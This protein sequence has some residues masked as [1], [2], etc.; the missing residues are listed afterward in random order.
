M[1]PSSL[2]HPSTRPCRL[3]S[4]LQGYLA[5]TAIKLW[6]AKKSDKKPEYFRGREE[7]L[8]RWLDLYTAGIDF[9]LVD[10]ELSRRIAHQL[11]PLPAAGGP[12]AGAVLVIA[13]PGPE[14]AARAAPA[15]T[16]AAA[17]GDNDADSQ[18]GRGRSR[19]RSRPASAGRAGSVDSSS[20]AAVAPAG[21][22]A[23]A[24]AD[25][26]PVLG[27]IQVLSL[28]LPHLQ[29]LA[30]D[31][32][33]VETALLPSDGSSTAT[34]VDMSAAGLRAHAAAAQQRRLDEARQVLL[35]TVPQLQ[36]ARFCTGEQQQQ[37]QL[38]DWMVACA[39]TDT[40]PAGFEL[41]AAR[42]A[43]AADPDLQEAL[44][45]V[46]RDRYLAFR[47]LPGLKLLGIVKM[48]QQPKAGS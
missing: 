2:T 48:V 24:A 29:L 14:P 20:S 43:V 3:T 27:S 41:Q 19:S 42:A 30:E 9:V 10:Q 25:A 1:P 7:L 44:A 26:S 8:A 11:P 40:L 33:F 18:A 35:D 46:G 31:K 37:Q 45:T 23:T 34:V 22:A 16:P 12:P 28:M 39:A 36:Q 6:A 21:Q 32:T 5:Y 15:A 38:V 47:D 17:A 4:L 13:E